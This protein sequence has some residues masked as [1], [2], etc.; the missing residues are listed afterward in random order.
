MACPKYSFTCPRWHACHWF[1]TPILRLLKGQKCDRIMAL[2]YPHSKSC[3][4]SSR[5]IYKV[6]GYVN[7]VVTERAVGNFSTQQVMWRS[8]ILHKHCGC[9]TSPCLNGSN[10]G[11]YH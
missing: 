3:K 5:G 10:T 11:A 9:I 1:T 8:T 7:A 4:D 6:K 2:R